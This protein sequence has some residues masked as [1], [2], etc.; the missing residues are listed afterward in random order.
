P[1]QDVRFSTKL[2]Y[3]S[4]VMLSAFLLFSV[5]PIVARALL[6]RLGGSSAVWIS[7]LAFFQL[8]LLLGYTYTAAV[9][10]ASRN[11]M[12]QAGL[13]FGLLALASL[14]LFTL[15]PR[16]LP[17]THMQAPQAQLF[18]LLSR[19][20]GLPFVVLSTT[21][22][23]LQAWYA[24]REQSAVPYRLFALSNIASLA[25]LLLYPTAAEPHLRLGTQFLLWRVLF[26]LDAALTSALT[27]RMR[28]AAPASGEVPPALHSPEP[29]SRSRS[30]E[31]A[32][33]AVASFQLAAVTAH[34]TQDVA[35]MPLLWVVPLAAYLLSFVVAF[36][37][38]RLYHRTFTLRLLAVLLFALGYFLAQTGFS[39]PIGLGIGVYTAELFLA[40]WF[41]HAELYA[42]RPREAASSTG[43]YLRIAAG[44]AAGA[45]AVAVL[46][47]LLTDSNFDLPFSF[48]LTA[49]LILAVTWRNGWPPRLFWAAG[50]AL[51]VYLLV[52]LHIAYAH[53][54]LFRARNFYGAIRVKQTQS[55]PQAQL[56]RTLYNGAIQH[57]M[58]WFSPAF[59]HAPLTYYA[60]DS[61][62]GLA[63]GH[64]FD[65]T[66]PRR[67]GVIGLGAGTL[68]AYGRPGDSI[69]FYEINPLVTGV[70]AN[71]FTYTRDT[72][73]TV[74]VV[75]GD[76]RLSLAAEPP[77]AFDLLVID[78]F[79]GDSI[80]T[81][82]LTREALAL[83]RRHLAPG[84]ILAFHISN[85]YLDLAPVL[86]RL[87]ED[88]GLGAREIDSGPDDARGESL[89]SW[90]LLTDRPAFFAQP[91]LAVA[92]PINTLPDVP[93]W[94]DEYSSLLPILR[95]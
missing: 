71:L 62:V 16:S 72:S 4:A 66:R 83:Y 34:L 94:T 82:L 30:L 65:P 13:H 40:A 32:L 59:K 54:A 44:G 73:A 12:W 42:L 88:A 69:R 53:D 1:R 21:A 49:A 78:A 27:W 20:V 15:D 67:I 52:L 38:P 74:T 11:R 23:L 80:P 77:Q 7:A 89:A 25:A 26:L 8:A 41:C 48:L 43:F 28:S 86:A 57:G 47:P 46:S 5:E 33:P 35:S 18:L 24:R 76:A 75:P 56:S 61:G 2:L 6:P 50:A 58:Q 51:G 81:H 93:L 36:Q 29:A 95:W 10:S 37:L 85:Q 63:L 22:P 87:V 90:V 9:A 17:V 92:R 45:L 60:P 84:G 68:A 19:S 39:L 64:G 91:A 31:L 79:S 3:T 70:A 55:P 14:A